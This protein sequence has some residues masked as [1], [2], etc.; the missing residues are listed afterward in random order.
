MTH[1]VTDSGGRPGPIMGLGEV[2]PL[3]AGAGYARNE[4]PFHETTRVV[5]VC[6]EVDFRLSEHNGGGFRI[7]ANAIF[8]VK[9]ALV[10]HLYVAAIDEP[11]IVEIMEM[12]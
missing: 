9:V 8:P 3:Q 2:H 1:F 11:G 6:G 10:K 12:T 5:Y 7:P 4:T